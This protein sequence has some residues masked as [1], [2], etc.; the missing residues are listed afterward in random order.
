ML[1]S[2]Y[3]AWE[4]WAK[5]VMFEEHWKMNRCLPD[6]EGKRGPFRRWISMFKGSQNLRR[7]WHVWEKGEKVT[8][9]VA[10]GARKEVAMKRKRM[11]TEGPS[12]A[13]QRR[14]DV[15]YRRFSAWRWLTHSASCFASFF[16]FLEVVQRL[17][18][19]RDQ[20]WKAGLTEE[21]I[22]T[23]LGQG[24]CKQEGRLRDI[25]RQTQRVWW[26]MDVCEWGESGCLKWKTR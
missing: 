2:P 17:G 13:L 6:R 1:Q 25:P 10:E 24:Q 15:F 14:L 21:V 19:N 5:E 26:W 16:L 4:N 9:V 11:E 3:S 12:V 18:L 23:E 22:M 20:E 7:V 8:V